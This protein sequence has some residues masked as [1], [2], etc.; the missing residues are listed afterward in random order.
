MKK[1]LSWIT[2]HWI[3]LIFVAFFLFLWIAPIGFGVYALVT[4]PESLVT[5]CNDFYTQE[6]AQEYY[7]DHSTFLFPDPYGL[8]GDDDG[9]ACESLP[10]GSDIDSMTDEELLKWINS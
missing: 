1:L 4:D 10:S 9:V 2:E 5:D 3:M 7:D 6:S 8:D